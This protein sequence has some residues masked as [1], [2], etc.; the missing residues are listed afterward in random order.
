MSGASI[1]ARPCSGKGVRRESEAPGRG[2]ADE[3]LAHRD[4]ARLPRFGPTNRSS[5]A[6]TLLVRTATFHDGMS[7]GRHDSAPDDS[8]KLE[9]Q[10]VP[11]LKLVRTKSVNRFQFESVTIFQCCHV[12]F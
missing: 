7:D 3:I 4:E 5:D 11:G 1:H 12:Q 2:S 10:L 6:G 8:N 9:Q